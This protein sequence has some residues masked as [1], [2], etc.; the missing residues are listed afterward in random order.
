MSNQQ[1]T[2]DSQSFWLDRPVFVTGCA[3]LL[4]SWLTI[5]LVEAG[6]NVVGLIRDKVPFSYLRR[7]GYQD[8]IVTT[9]LN[10]P[11]KNMGDRRGIGHHLIRDAMN[12][13]NLLRHRDCRLH[14]LLKLLRFVTI[15]PKL[16]RC[17][18]YDL[19]TKRQQSGRFGV[20]RNKAGRFEEV[21]HFQAVIH[22]VNLVDFN[23]FD[24]RK[25]DC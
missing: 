9:E 20:K 4:G 8:R 12:L 21:T 14:Q 10:E 13:D 24:N 7:S 16:D 25:I 3:G 18:L 15:Q 5:A 6:A 23:P 2:Y 11:G 19:V 1:M 17:Q 22:S